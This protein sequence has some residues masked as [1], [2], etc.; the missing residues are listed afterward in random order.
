MCSENIQ[1]NLTK[2]TL[3]K[4][5]QSKWD[6]LLVS[7]CSWPSQTTSQLSSGECSAATLILAQITTQIQ[8]E[9]HTHTHT[10]T[11]VKNSRYLLL[12][13][14][15]Q[16]RRCGVCHMLL[17]LLLH[18]LCVLCCFSF[19]CQLKTGWSCLH[20]TTCP[21]AGTGDCDGDDPGDG[22]DVLA[23]SCAATAAG[24][25]HCLPADFHL[26]YFIVY[27]SFVGCKLCVARRRTIGAKTNS[28][29]VQQSCKAGALLATSAQCCVCDKDNTASRLDCF[30]LCTSE[31]DIVSHGHLQPLHEWR[32]TREKLRRKS[33]G[34]AELCNGKRKLR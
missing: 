2:R 27:T 1:I 19:V 33:F 30:V 18:V 7:S 11:Q 17:L 8:L 13:P 28:L 12:G 25:L 34:E 3:I 5:G 4:K 31:I 9:N 24:I 29:V 32:S 21:A 23:S 16:G 22:V 10:L 26:Q 15:D 14:C 6:T 20:A